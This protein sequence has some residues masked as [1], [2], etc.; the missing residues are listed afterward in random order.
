ML[1]FPGNTTRSCSWTASDWT[2]GLSET[3]VQV[4][5]EADQLIVFQIPLLLPPRYI[6]LELL[7]SGAATSMRPAKG[8]LTGAG[9]I[10]VQWLALKTTAGEGPL[11]TRVTGRPIINKREIEQVIQPLG[12]G[13]KKLPREYVVGVSIGGFSFV[14]F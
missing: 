10:G 13:I 12:L 8:P 7:G 14:E 9:P 4:G 2:A 11:S 6:T 5:D 1:E 3:A